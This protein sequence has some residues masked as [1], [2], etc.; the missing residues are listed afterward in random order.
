MKRLA[1]LVAGLTILI[2]TPQA[3]RTGPLYD[4]VVAGDFQTVSGYVAQGLF[5]DAGDLGTPLNAAIALGNKDIAVLL[6]DHGAGVEASRGASGMRPLH[7]AASYRHPELVSLLLARRAK[8]DARDNF[9]RTP[10]LIAASIGDAETARR[11]LDRG[12]NVNVTGK[13]DHTP[14][15]W[16]VFLGKRDLF[17]VVI[18]FGADI[19]APSLHG[20][21]PLH[22][23]AMKG[24]LEMIGRLA[25]L[26][27][28]I[29]ARR[30][31]GQTPLMLAK[32]YDNEEAV[33][34][35][36]RLGA[37]HVTHVAAQESSAA[38]PTA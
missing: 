4:A 18:D 2:L 13:L 17:N 34:L 24:S 11:L 9:G 12:A 33:A 3:V 30:K 25:A 14:L 16:A 6:M 21:T 10:L 7:F 31:D 27:A 32:G 20:E 23:A 22:M 15:H 28:D 37:A 36:I 8:V 5:E 26:G 35:L 19:D 1:P 38:S 29:N